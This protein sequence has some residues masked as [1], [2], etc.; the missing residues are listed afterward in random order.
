MGQWAPQI[1]CREVMPQHARQRDAAISVVEVVLLVRVSI[2]RAI[3]RCEKGSAAATEQAVQA[4]S[5]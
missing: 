4:P 3:T 5:V 2:G 1:A